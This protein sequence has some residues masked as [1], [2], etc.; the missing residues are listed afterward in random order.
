MQNF[1]ALIDSLIFTP[2]RNGKLR[3]LTDYFGRAEDPDRGYALASLTGSLDLK[4]AKPALV[5]GLVTE[6]VDPV[7]FGWSY[8]YVGDLAETVS[9]IWPTPPGE[10]GFRLSEIVTKAERASRGEM[11]ALLAGWLDACS[12]AE[13]YALIK[14]ITGGMRVGVSTRLAKVAL[15]QFGDKPVEEIEELWHGLEPPYENLFAWLEGRADRPEIDQSLVFRPL[16]LAHPLAE[17]EEAGLDAA[18]FAA[19]WKWDGIRVQI[20]GH[21]GQAKLFSRTGDDISQAFP[22]IVEGLAFDGV[23]D[24]ELLVVREGEV[25]PFAHL[26]KRLN[27]K[28]VG[29]KM[30]SDNPA[31]VRLYDI[32]FDGEEDL[33]GL[34]F[35]DRRGRLEAWYETSAPHRMDVSPLVSFE[36]WEELDRLRTDARGDVVEGVMIKRLDSAYLAGRP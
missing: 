35:A 16:M 7:L 19:E 5:R 9:L 14:L 4:A 29:A 1:A 31:W 13:R 26:Q 28:R 23:V 3:H 8:D 15:A 20:A 24:G 6:R 27:R 11:P 2:S 12:I 25:Q 21:G 22:D 10:S 36:S 32:L 30:L 34:S 18:A 33:R 17:G